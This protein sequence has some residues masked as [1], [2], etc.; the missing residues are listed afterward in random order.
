M[1]I[2]SKTIKNNSRCFIIA[3]I[4]TSHMGDINRAFKLIDAVA[5]AGADCAKFQIVIADEIIHPKTGKVRLPGGNIDLYANFKKLEKDTGFYKKLKEY[6]ENRGLVFLCTPFGIK[7]ARMLKSLNPAAVK[8]ASPELNHFPLLKEVSGYGCPLILSTGVSKLKDIEAA[9]NIVTEKNVVLLHCITAYP[10]PAEE[11]NLR[12]IKNLSSIFGIPAGISDHSNDP[13]LIPVTGAGIGACII[14]KH[15]ALSNNN[16]G[17]DDPFALTKDNF[18]KM[19]KQIR[20]IEE[21]KS[22]LPGNNPEEQ[23]IK[24]LKNMFGSEKT[25]IIL[26]NGIKKLADSEKDNYETTRRTIK[27]LIT[28][29]KGDLITKKNISILRSEKNLK[30]GLGPEFY[31]LIC[32]K[33]VR[34]TVNEGEGVNWEHLI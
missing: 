26:G 7:S 8:I 19:V 4:G 10:A 11:F 24:E 1:K 15:F 16:Q 30:P 25:N 3:E 23:V 22:G 18:L 31:D 34:K 6:T 17:L 2:G 33:T 29:N 20:K 5:E 27:A 28:I 21:I 13:F 32:G 9:L 12:L 14:E